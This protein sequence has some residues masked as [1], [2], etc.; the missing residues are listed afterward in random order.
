MPF[1]HFVFVL[2]PAFLLEVGGFP[3]GPLLVEFELRWG[4]V[5]CCLH[6]LTILHG[7]RIA[8]VIFNCFS[9]FNCRMV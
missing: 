6:V 4:G 1:G 7:V 2:L 8:T 9:F 5:V 3:R